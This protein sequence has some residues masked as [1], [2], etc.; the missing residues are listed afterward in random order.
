MRYLFQ[1]NFAVGMGALAFSL[2]LAGCQIRP[3]SA[4]EGLGKLTIGPNDDRRYQAMMLDNGL[5]VILI[6]DKEVDRSAAA[7]AIS[8]GSY[9]EP[10][11]REGLAHFLE[12]M[13]FLGTKRYPDPEGFMSFIAANGGQNNAYTASDHTN[14]FFEIGDVNF[15][16]ALDRFGQFF[17]APLFDATY[18]DKERKAVH[19]EYQLQSKDDSWRISSVQRISMNPNH[20][21][22]RFNIGSEETLAD[23]GTKVRNDLIRF[24]E[25]HY[26]ANRMV[27]TVLSP[28]SLQQQ[29]RWIRLSFS[30]IPPSNEL[31]LVV[32]APL[33]AQDQLPAMLTVKPEKELRT[34]VFDF[35]VP[36]VQAHYRAK[37]AHYIANLLGTEAEG[38]L[39]AWLK[40]RGW[41]EALSASGGPLWR[42]DSFISVNMTLTEAGSEHWQEVGDALFA[43]IRLLKSDS[44]EHW[45]FLEESQLLSLKFRFQ[46]RSAP[47]SY[48]RYIASNALQYPLVDSVYAPY[49]M[50]DWSPKLITEY[51][52]L[53]TPERALIT[54]VDPTAKTA[55][56]ERWFQV[57]YQLG[58]IPQS[59]ID[60]WNQ[61]VLPTGIHLP[62]PNQFIPENLQLADVGAVAKL[63]LLP[64][65]GVQAW[66]Y[67]DVSFALPN[68]VLYFSLKNKQQ[69]PTAKQQATIALYLALV[70]E[71]LN[72]Y[73][74]PALLA[75]LSYSATPSDAGMLL[76]IRGY[77]DSQPKLLAE[78]MQAV[79]KTRID[80]ARMMH[81]QAELS[82]QWRNSLK[83]RP[84]VRNLVA[85]GDALLVPK[86]RAQ[87]LAAAVEAL[88]LQDIIHWRDDWFANVELAAFLYGNLDRQQAMLMVSGVASVLSSRADTQPAA[89]QLVN[90]TGLGSI[91]H[92]EMVD[93]TDA[94][95]VLYVQGESQS[96]PERAKFALLS[97]MLR[98][99]YFQHV[100]TEKQLGYVAAA[101]S[102]LW[103]KTPGLAFVVQSPVSSA[104]SLLDTTL[105]FIANYGATIERLTPAVFQ[106]YKKA[107]SAAI[108]TKDKN[109]GQRASRLW[110]ELRSGEF[111]LDSR[112]RLVEAIAMLNQE[113]IVLFYERFVEAVANRSFI[114]YNEGKMQ[115]KIK[116]DSTRRPL[117]QFYGL[118]QS[119][120]NRFRLSNQP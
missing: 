82:R 48:V 42:Q 5:R 106:G 69:Q 113:D 102:R 77:S 86:W 1:L 44:V 112:Q 24:Y 74:Y 45:R 70:R 65:Q 66:H 111:N 14:Y 3:M 93:H 76:S 51:L 53:L 95:M 25:Q 109:P 21:A 15:A 8:A 118:K 114:S 57:H 6:Q 84:Y 99:D 83:D 46:H 38:S 78:L 36:A 68:N 59:A 60:H 41:I 73:G 89:L 116:V 9:D 100:R 71:A 72:E 26:R 120:W 34:L 94:A 28:Y 62:K 12:H 96:M 75:G 30:D 2:L 107:L 29:L 92:Q 63:E 115:K 54:R 81:Y 91:L 17:I 49:A 90:L 20:P 80:P 11:E 4:V 108:L 10:A 39:H 13:L 33:F 18:V 40:K 56:V 37:P 104:P 103:V 119:G 22:S 87:E 50:L 88:S 105:A 61:A 85:M 52:D 31:P 79:T 101:R 67:P 97:Q 23:K 16:E 19:S 55:A 27:L 35:P 117:V 7:M 43:Y 32:S 64:V 98:A 47:L 110:R 58:K